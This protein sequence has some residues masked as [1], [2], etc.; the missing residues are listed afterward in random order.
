MGQAIGNIKHTNIMT[1][2][3]C[4]P[5]KPSDDLKQLHLAQCTVEY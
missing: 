2:Q 1:D 3:R 4:K 5:N